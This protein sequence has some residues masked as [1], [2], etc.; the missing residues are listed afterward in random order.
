[1]RGR[2]IEC[3]NKTKG[4]KKGIA[5]NQAGL[6]RALTVMDGSFRNWLVDLEDGRG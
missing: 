4:K 6:G 3:K 5:Y 2:E 1:M